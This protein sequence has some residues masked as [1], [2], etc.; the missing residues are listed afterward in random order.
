MQN[1]VSHILELVRAFI[2]GPDRG[3]QQAGVIETELQKLPDNDIS[4][5]DIIIALACY[6]P[7]GGPHLYNENEMIEMLK[8]YLPRLEC[9]N[10]QKK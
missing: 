2:R 5:Q 4:T 8:S 9:P 1:N 6:R 3:I 7:E 10:D